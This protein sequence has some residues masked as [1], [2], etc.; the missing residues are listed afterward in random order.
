MNT[1]PKKVTLYYSL[2]KNMTVGTTQAVSLNIFTM[3]LVFF[4]NL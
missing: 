1:V 2:N 4:M 3:E